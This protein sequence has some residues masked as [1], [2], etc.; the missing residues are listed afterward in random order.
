MTKK[1]DIIWLESVDSTNKEAQRRISDIDNLSVLS[2]NQQTEGRGQRG[3]TWSSESGKNLLFSVVMKF[4]DSIFDGKFLPAINSHDQFV[5]SETAA[6]SV[7][8]LLAENDTEAKIKWP[9]DIYVGDRKIC[10]ILI[11]NSLKGNSL[12]HS[13]LG[14]G[15][16][17]NQTSFDPSLPNP[18]SI[19]LETGR[20]YD[21]KSLLERYMEIFCHYLSRYCNP[22]GGYARLR[23]LYLSQLWRNGETSDFIDRTRKQE[24]KFKG[25]IEGLSDIGHLIIKTEEGELREFSFQEIS[26][27]I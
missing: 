7:V 23:K 3:N 5:I 1:H 16:N 8:D 2:A 17:V 26:F 13:I 24:Y 10:G 21:L 11:E 9:N 14:I 4:S 15:L 18:T 12:S 6:L 19:T 27:I 20:T 22:H 25:T